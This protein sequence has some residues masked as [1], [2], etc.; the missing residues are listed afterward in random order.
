MWTL[1]L[2]DLALM[3][4]GARVLS[5]GGGGDVFSAGLVVHQAIEDHGPIRVVALG[6]LPDDANLATIAV[7]GAPTAMNEKIATG[8]QI[9]AV[10]AALTARTGRPLDAVL[11]LEV[12]GMNTFIPLA[13]AAELGAPCVDADGMR[14]VLPKGELTT[15]TLGG[16]AAAPLAVGDEKGNIMLFDSAS[17]K[18]ACDIARRTSMALGLACVMAC[19]PM[20][21]AQAKATAVDRS[22]SYCLQVGRLL[23]AVQRGGDDDW[24]AFFAGTGGR[25]LYEGRVIGVDREPTHDFPRG[26]ITLESVAD[27]L[28]TLRVEMQNELVLAIKDGHVVVTPPDLLCLLDLDNSEPLTTEELVYGQRARILALPAAPEWWRPGVLDLV[29]P[30]AFGYDV[31]AVAFP[32]DDR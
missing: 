21:A 32:Q 13:L 22:L 24:A 10:M 15:F 30:K 26:S 25:L 1:D 14:R 5:A 19:Y 18:L 8:R 2:P 31:S 6:E 28:S 12:G 4:L 7:I 27:R 29:G 3:G 17:N 23:E 20:S 16:V 9:V 11:P